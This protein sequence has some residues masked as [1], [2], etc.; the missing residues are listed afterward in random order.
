MSAP[1]GTRAR[2]TS[3]G[4]YAVECHEQNPMRGGYNVQVIHYYA[5]RRS[6]ELDAEQRNAHR[7]GSRRYYA[8]DTAE[9]G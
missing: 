5:R 1:R 7:G 4:R 2:A 8:R 3:C 9:A 6:A